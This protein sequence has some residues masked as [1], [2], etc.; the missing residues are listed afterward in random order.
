MQVY[1]ITGLKSVLNRDFN[2]NSQ[3]R[4]N[5]LM[6]NSNVSVSFGAENV[7]FPL[8]SLFKNAISK[9]SIRNDL[10]GSIDNWEVTFKKIDDNSDVIVLFRHHDNYILKA[11]TSEKDNKIKKKFVYDSTVNKLYKI[12]NK[13]VY[14][15]QTELSE[16]DYNYITKF[17]K[18]ALNIKN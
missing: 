8:K 1:K 7:P 3:Q 10:K 17:I 14:S 16:E 2:T 4:N 13:V 15:N 5:T 12:E 11:K 6:I 9:L 18:A